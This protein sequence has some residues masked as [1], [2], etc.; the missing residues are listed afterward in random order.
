MAP[1]MKQSRSKSKARSPAS[2]GRSGKRVRRQRTAKNRLTY[3]IAIVGAGPAGRAA[4]GAATRLG[5]RV[6]LLERRRLGGTSLNSGSV[7]SKALI[8][9]A[10]LF[11]EIRE[12]TRLQG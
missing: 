8:R 1:L 5:A 7:P 11:A 2:H 3:D 9:S 4:A 12:A 6:A 10:T